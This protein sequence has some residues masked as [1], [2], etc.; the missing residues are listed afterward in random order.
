MG[1]NGKTFVVDDLMM[2][3]V[4]EVLLNQDMIVY[5]DTDKTRYGF[6]TGN[7][8]VNIAYAQAKRLFETFKITL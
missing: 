6:I 5:N 3:K 4:L 8:N 7:K 2:A 1:N